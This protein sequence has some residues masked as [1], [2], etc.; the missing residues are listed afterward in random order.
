MGFLVIPYCIAKS[1]DLLCEGQLVRLTQ[2]VIELRTLNYRT[3]IKLYIARLY[4][5]SKML[6]QSS[7]KGAFFRTVLLNLYGY[8]NRSDTRISTN[9]ILS[10]GVALTLFLFCCGYSLSQS[11]ILYHF[12]VEPSRQSSQKM[13]EWCLPRVGA[14]F[15]DPDAQIRRHTASE[16]EEVGARKR[17]DVVLQAHRLANMLW[18]SALSWI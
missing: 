18:L 16:A 9:T 3:L 15:S 5:T 7:I 12:P 11:R 6:F 17:G 2:L 13:S 10:T 4:S 8:T 14:Y 1:T